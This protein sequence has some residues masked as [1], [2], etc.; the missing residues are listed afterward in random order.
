MEKEIKLMQINPE[1]TA[2]KIGSF[3][4][5]KIIEVGATGGVIGL[6]GGVDSTVSAAIVKKAFDR[7]N[8]LAAKKLELVGFIIPSKI[9]N[10]KDTRDGVTIAKKLKIKYEVINIE[11]IV[12][13]HQKTNPE[14]MK[15][16]YHKGNMI[17][18]IRANVLLTKAAT[19]KKIVIGTGNKDE[20]FGVGYYTLFGDGAVHISPIGNLSKRLVRQMAEYFGFKDIARKEPTAGLEKGQTDFL[21]LGYGYDLVELV[22]EGLCQGFKVNELYT[23][24]QI[25][26]LA[27]KQMAINKKFKKVKEI[28]DDILAR[29]RDV[30]LPKA[31]IVHPPIAPIK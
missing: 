26:Q 6:S 15:K 28:V 20:D 1:K 21:D 17:S 19:E 14:A 11:S 2:E 5:K 13:A 31:E 27:K 30:A 24:E 3:V 18:R 12:K 29:H 8:R 25:T 9:N 23:Q 7:H 10:P 4:V 16:Q 22:Y